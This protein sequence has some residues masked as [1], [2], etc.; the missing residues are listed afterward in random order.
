VNVLVFSG[1]DPSGGAG[2]NA[3]IETLHTNQVNTLPIATVLTAQ[4][5]QTFKST[6]NVDVN[7]IKQQYQ[8]IED[9]FKIDAIKLGLLGDKKQL[10]MIGNILRNKNIPIVCDPIISTSSGE[11]VMSNILDFKK[12]IL[13][14]ITLLTPNKKEYALLL[15]EEKTLNC[16]WVLITAGDDDTEVIQHQLLHKGKLVKTFEF[17]KLPFHYHGSGCT[18]SSSITAFLA[19]GDTMESACEKGLNYTYE[20]LLA[21]KKI[22]ANNYRPKR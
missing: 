20:S 18:L 19:K 4:N 5:S 8:L 14:Y 16:P 12:Y 17:K 6:Y 21:A 7:L 9:E 11:L 10:S 15:N 2:L 13:P 22:G 3:D 1:L